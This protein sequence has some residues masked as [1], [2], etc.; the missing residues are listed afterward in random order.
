MSD[1]RPKTAS[2]KDKGLKTKLYIEPNILGGGD[3]LSQVE[4]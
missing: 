4:S 1:K 2:L 3:Y